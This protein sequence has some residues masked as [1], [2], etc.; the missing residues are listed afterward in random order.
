MYI[1]PVVDGRHLQVITWSLQKSSS[2]WTLGNFSVGFKLHVAAMFVVNVLEKK[3]R[4][5]LHK[6]VKFMVQNIM[7][8]CCTTYHCLKAGAHFRNF[9]MDRKIIFL[10]HEIIF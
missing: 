5:K 10:R 4:M 1:K 3:S 7:L 9:S 8:F 2:I 6:A